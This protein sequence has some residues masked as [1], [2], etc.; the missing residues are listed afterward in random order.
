M[1]RRPADLVVFI[2]ARLVQLVPVLLGIIILTFFFSRISVADPCAAWLGSKASKTAIQGCINYFGLRLPLYV[3]FERYFAMLLTGNWGVDPVGNQPV[4]PLLLSAFPETLEL[5]LAAVLIM[6]VIGI[7][8]GVVAA[9]APGRWPD[10]VVRIVYLIGW[11][12]PTYLIAGILA[13]GVGPLIG[14]TGGDFSRIPTFPQP[15]H[16][17]VLDALLAGNLPATGDALTH[18]AL[19]AFA[20]AFLNLGVVTRMTRTSMLET[21]PM[22]YVRAAQMKGLSDFVVLFKHALRNS[23]ITTTTVIGLT[24]GYLLGATIV[25][26]ELFEWPGIGQYAYNVM[27]SYDFAGTIGFVVF[28]AIGVVVANLIADVL[29]GVLDPRVEWR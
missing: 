24:A 4:L 25:V 12:T 19:P 7:P 27:T 20:L 23:L 8:M 17:S 2:G 10:H 9:A 21:L 29:Y 5:V 13:L 3:Q 26:E 11:S 28:A 14:V 16:M 18:L 15:T 6:V 1:S 22:E